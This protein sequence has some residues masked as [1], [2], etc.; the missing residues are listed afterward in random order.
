M[1]WNSTTKIMTAPL[2]INAG[3][4]IQNASGVSSGD[5]GYCLVNGNWNK[6]AK[7][8]PVKSSAV[9]A[10]TENDLVGLNYGL[11]IDVCGPNGNISSYISAFGSQWAYDKPNGSTGEVYRAFDLT[12]PSGRTATG[13]NGNAAS[14]INANDQTLPSS[15]LTGNGGTGV[16]FRIGLTPA[17]QLPAGSVLLTDLHIGGLTEDVTL[18]AMYLGL[19]FVTGSTCLIVTSSNPMSANAYGS[20]ITIAESNGSLTGITTGTTYAVYP[21]LSH[22]QHATL[23]A[24]AQTDR[25]LALPVSPFSFKAS[26][27]S[28]AQNLSIPRKTAYINERA[29]LCVSF[30]VGMSATGG[31]STTISDAYYTLYSASSSGDTSG[32][33]ITSGAVGTLTTST[34]QTVTLTLLTTNPGWVRIY[35]NRSGD[36]TVNA[37]AW[38]RVSDAEIPVPVD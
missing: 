27:V 8:K 13:Y 26:Q 38:V 7:Y 22:Q 20:E 14:F 24:F 10:L 25:V 29:R 3:G 28:T 30:T 32:S 31:A 11:T 36:P 15:Y 19:V 6:W 33:Q 21:V 12:N 9:G 1:P 37:E 34:T 18:S 5:L 4:D 16:T 2:N 23:T 17:A 35:V